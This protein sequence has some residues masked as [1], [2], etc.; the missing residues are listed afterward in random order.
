MSR[1]YQILKTTDKLT[2]AVENDSPERAKS[3]LIELRDDIRE[4]QLDDET[5]P[6]V[7]GE[8]EAIIT[9][10]EMSEKL[11][12]DIPNRIFRVSSRID[13]L[14]ARHNEGDP[15]QSIE[16]IRNERDLYRKKMLEY[17]RSIRELSHMVEKK[18]AEMRV[19]RE[20]AEKRKQNMLDRSEEHRSSIQDST[21]AILGTDVVE[22]LDE[23]KSM[24]EINMLSDEEGE[25]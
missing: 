17:E 8:V 2:Q 23:G 22:K 13:A 7:I 15:E 21:E 25:T 1:I 11:V 10:L 6:E 12:D 24:E 5:Y 20:E 14:Y 19:R 16:D 4:Y 18:K 9:S 3:T